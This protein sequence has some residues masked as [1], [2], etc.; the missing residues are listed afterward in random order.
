MLAQFAFFYSML[1][2]VG[3]LRL[4]RSA[5]AS[6]A[7]VA[8]RLRTPELTPRLSIRRLMGA[9][10]VPPV[11]WVTLAAAIIFGVNAAV[12]WSMAPTG[13]EPWYM[14]Q[15]YALL[16]FHTPSV[17]PIVNHPA[18][19]QQFLSSPDDHSRDYLGNGE[20][21]LPYLPGYALVIAPVYA[22]AG[23][24]GIIALQSLLVALTAALLF[25]TAERTFRSRWCGIFAALAYATTVPAFHYAGQVFPSTV[26]ACA[27]F[28]GLLLAVGE[29]PH[30]SGRRL[31]LA[32]GGIGAVVFALPWL[33]VKYAPAALA[34]AVVAALAL[35][36]RRRQGSAGR[37]VPRALALLVGCLALS[38]LL[39]VLY[40]HTYC[41]TWMPHLSPRPG[42]QSDPR[43]W[44]PARLAALLDDM[45]LSR[46]SGLLPWVPL[47]FLALPGLALLVWRRRRWG[48]A[49][50]AVLAGQL[51]VFLIAVVT[52]DIS[53]GLAFPARFTVECGPLLA[54]CA[55]ALLAEALRVVHRPAPRGSS[56]RFLVRTIGAAT[57]AL[58]LAPALAGAYF[59]AATLRD[60]SRLYP[61]SA[62]PRLVM[63]YPGL[64]PAWWFV[65]FPE[66]P[67]AVL[68][69]RSAPFA[70]MIAAPR[71]LAPDG[72][73]ATALAA[74]WLDVPPGRFMATVSFTCAP[75]P[76]TS[77]P[78]RVIAQ[79]DDGQ[80][81]IIAER[82]VP[83][84]ACTGAPIRVIVPFAS[85]GYQATRFAIVVPLGAPVPTAAMLDYTRAP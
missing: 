84:P 17:A 34:L 52:P 70:R 18:L 51:G 63:A 49:V 39:I 45:F 60:V 73:R 13:D 77:G 72:V 28:A 42:A 53:Q 40:S 11:A 26:A 25:A 19:Y 7:A 79:R 78:L 4:A 71:A 80:R 66:S 24:M 9:W 3:R 68:Y 56:R 64:F 62:G 74:P 59:T 12:A 38:L 5:R 32:S 21:M 22:V 30:A 75:L 50:A 33:H 23:R 6:A 31:L 29:L 36:W 1:S 20:R 35:L 67:G 2:N 48:L 58:C 55:T 16:H 57:L 81:S 82:I 83:E 69:Q 15:A 8:A 47:D 43:Y 54:L 27:T 41:G 10:R 85:I 61:S 37:E 46:Q 44:S 14:M 65:R 76:A